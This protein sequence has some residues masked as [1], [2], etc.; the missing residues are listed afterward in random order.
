MSATAK[1]FGHYSDDDEDNDLVPRPNAPLELLDSSSSSFR[2]IQPPPSRKKS[3]LY[4]LATIQAFLIIY[5]T[6]AILSAL[7]AA[8]LSVAL[9]AH[10][11]HRPAPRRRRRDP[12]ASAKITHDY[13]SSVTSKYD[14][15]LGSID[16]WCLADETGGENDNACSCEDPLEPVAKNSSGKWR[17]QHKENVK[18]VTEVLM[19]STGYVEDVWGD[20][21]GYQPGMYDD[22]WFERPDDDWVEGRGA[23]FGMDDFGMG[24][25]VGTGDDADYDYDDRFG[26]PVEAP[27]ADPEKGE[28]T[29]EMPMQGGDGR[30]LATDYELD[31]VF[32]GDSITEQ[33]QGTSMGRE[34][35]DY[36][37][38]KEVFQKTFSKEKGGDF[39]GIALGIAGDTAPNLLWRLMNGEMPYG[40]NP[41][42]WWVGIGI[43]DLSMK[44]CSE[45]VVLLGILRVVEEIQNAH[46]DAYI[47]INSLLP[48]RR[49]E[50]GLLEH[51]GKHHEHKALKDK[52]KNLQDSEM[53][54][55]RMHID[56]WPSIVSINEELSKFASKH[57]GI[58]FF[59]ADQVFVEE[60]DGG[61]YL[62]LD[63]MADAVHPNL[64]GHK[65]WNGAIKKRLH[66]ILD[67][68][69]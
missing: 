4:Y 24:A 61:K 19:K 45:E 39:N 60:R 30:M 68:K 27:P 66:S 23:R 53:S 7:L 46:P 34:N 9:T 31:V 51:T 38:I 13:A 55:K 57:S 44:G 32:V 2:P 16:H 33:R 67:G 65:K 3:C 11:S 59:D 37:G 12:F 15:T 49:N 62:K 35:E 69:E 43:N 36:V 26:I 28:D 58:K 22:Q 10:L 52:E 5:R 41:K 6:E 47:V 14:L 20:Y 21:G 25:Y 54:P 50:D 18:V 48:V 1:E 42:V 8:S 64:S 17:D 40:L 56:L 29:M 63:L